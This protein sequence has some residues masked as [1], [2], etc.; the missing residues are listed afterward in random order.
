MKNTNLIR[1]KKKIFFPHSLDRIKK[2]L[3]FKKKFSL[4][5]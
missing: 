2:K 1:E 3:I 4:Q 5:P